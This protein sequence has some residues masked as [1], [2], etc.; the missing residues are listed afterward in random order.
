MIYFG[1]AI[2]GA[3]AGASSSYL[4]T[5]RRE[6]KQKR[7]IKNAGNRK[8]MDIK[9][10]C[11]EIQSP[12]GLTKV[13]EPVKR[14][15]LLSQISKF[16]LDKLNRVDLKDQNVKITD[17]DRLL[18]AMKNK[19]LNLKKT[20]QPQPTQDKE[21]KLLA[22]IQKVRLR[23]VPRAETVEEMITEEVTVDLNRLIASIREIDDQLAGLEE[24]QRPLETI[25]LSDSGT[26][27]DDKLRAE[28]GPGEKFR[29]SPP[30]NYLRRNS[31]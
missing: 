9:Q 29:L 14:E 17:V 5:L 16:Q 19:K 30:V 8:K 11:R 1:V 22:S 24:L 26:E 31:I 10:L 12:P 2:V 23:R 18:F 28:S 4:A 13:Q 21:D 25:S 15:N 20:E 6:R 7:V 3:I 27:D